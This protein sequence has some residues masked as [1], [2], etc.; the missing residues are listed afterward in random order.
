LAVVVFYHQREGVSDGLVLAN[1][2]GCITTAN[3]SF[4]GKKHD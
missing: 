1:A 3:E 2:K 4:D